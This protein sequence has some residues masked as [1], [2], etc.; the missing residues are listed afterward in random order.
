[1]VVFSGSKLTRS[2]SS[3]S[4]VDTN[5]NVLVQETPYYGISKEELQE[6]RIA[7]RERLG[8]DYPSAVKLGLLTDDEIT[9]EFENEFC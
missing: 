2:I 6:I 3:Y 7:E 9:N 1:M 5:E 8:L 4:W